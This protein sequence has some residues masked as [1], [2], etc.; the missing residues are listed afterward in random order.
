MPEIYTRRLKAIT[1]D[2]TANPRIT[3]SANKR[4]H[5]LQLQLTY[6]AGTNTLAGLAAA[7]TEIRVLVGT[8]PR[9][10]LNGTQLRDFLLL[11][12][13]TFDWNGLPNTGAQITLPFAPE[14]FLENV[15]D[16]LAWNPALLGG[17][18]TVE[19]DSTMA[20]TC[21]VYERVSDDL[22]A[23]S[24]GIITLEVIKPVAGGT[25]FFVEKEL[26]PVGRLMLA[27]I[28]PDTTN[29]NAITPASLFVGPDDTYAHEALTS[30]QNLEA[31]ERF[32]LT[33]SATGRTANLY[34]MV[35]VKGDALSRAIDLA[36]WGSAKFKVEAAGA[37]AGTCSI[38][39]ARLEPK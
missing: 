30:A 19:I 5:S 29:N 13:T 1:G 12:G 36:R 23:V 4:I 25:A 16:S 15:A 14:W 11:F 27:S 18:I 38:L 35:F 20:L 21:V 37:M 28:Y 39:L 2:G 9:W 32:S 10:R 24:S 22:N 26:N 17:P 8:K 3:P 31:L 34:D 33:P 6:A 7:L